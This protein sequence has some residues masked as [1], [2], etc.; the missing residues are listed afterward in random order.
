MSDNIGDT[1]EFNTLAE[2]WQDYFRN[3]LE[4]KGYTAAMS[5]QLR[6]IFY[7]GAAAA[8]SLLGKKA[9]MMRGEIRDIIP[10]AD[11]LEQP[12]TH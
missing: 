1:T 10:P 12:G 9:Y 11:Q 6:F 4:P 3:A 5:T 7:A 8:I 2:E